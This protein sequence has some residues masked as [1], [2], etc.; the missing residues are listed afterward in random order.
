MGGKSL[1]LNQMKQWLIDLKEIIIVFFLAVW[2]M[3]FLVSQN[4]VPSGSMMPTLNV[5]DRIIVSMLPY[6]YR[7]P[8]R[9]ELVVFNGPDGEKWIKRVIALP[10]ETIDIREGDIYINGVWLDETAYLSEPHISSNNPVIASEISFPYTVPDKSYFLLGDNRLESYDCRYIGAI[11]QVD[12]M[13]KAI[14]RIYP[15]SKIGFIEEN[16]YGVS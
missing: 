11:N 15:F 8:R 5:N 10:G 14:Y 16:E 4:K 9:G 2:I 6:Y 3:T 12:V 7:S 1:I 13:G